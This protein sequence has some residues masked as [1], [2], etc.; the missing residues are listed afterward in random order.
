[1]IGLPVHTQ[2]IAGMGL[3]ICFSSR[4]KRGPLRDPRDG[5]VLEWMKALLL[6]MTW[7]NTSLSVKTPR[8]LT[9][10]QRFI[11]D[12]WWWTECSDIVLVSSYYWLISVGKPPGH[13]RLAIW[14]KMPV[15]LMQAI[16]IA[17]KGAM[18]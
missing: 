1:M 18:V 7:N 5:M 17:G 13:L 4:R 9:E 16:M 14:I 15:S 12:D 2:V 10:R 3:G 11:H 8:R 6:N